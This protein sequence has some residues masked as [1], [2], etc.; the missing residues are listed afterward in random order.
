MIS[1]YCVRQLHHKMSESALS[2][3]CC[4]TVQLFDVDKET[5]TEYLTGC[6]Q[7]LCP[8]VTSPSAQTLHSAPSSSSTLPSSLPVPCPSSWFPPFLHPSLALSAQ[9]LSDC[10]IQLVNSSLQS[11]EIAWWWANLSFLFDTFIQCFLTLLKVKPV[12]RKQGQAE[13]D[14]NIRG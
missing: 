5:E 4:S 12:T 14:M 3:C 9:P 1:T 2:T 11:W 10:I 8:T 6:L 7:H 13:Q